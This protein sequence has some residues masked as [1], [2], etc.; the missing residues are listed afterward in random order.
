[1]LRVFLLFSDV[2]MGHNKNEH[3]LRV[4]KCVLFDIWNFRFSGR[5]AAY[6]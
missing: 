3:Y 4:N 6:H 2:K 5:I 1:M